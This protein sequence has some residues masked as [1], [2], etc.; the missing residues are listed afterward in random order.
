MASFGGVEFDT[1]KM[2]IRLLSKKL[3]KAK[4][5]VHE[6]QKAC[7]VSLVELQR[8][9]GFLNFASIVIPL[10]RTFLRRLYN[11]QLYF[12]QGK[13]QMRR[14]LSAEAQKDLVLWAKVL[15]LAPERSNQVQKWDI[16]SLWS[17]AAG[18]KELGA[19]YTRGT[20]QYSG[21]EPD[22]AFSISLPSY[23]ARAREHINTKEMR[24]VEQAL[25]YWSRRWK[26]LKV[27]IHVDNRAVAQGLENQTIRG[28]PMTILRRCL[29]LAAEHDLDLEARWIPTKENALADALSWF[30][31][32][33]IDNLAS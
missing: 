24:V 19:F 20:D 5:I 18:I 11:M 4:L 8:I 29:L 21:P 26:G 3:Q 17:D 6:A 16:V 13:R 14:R 30:D 7:S 10:G 27:I 32:D 23:I 33:R 2:I 25:L 15:L 22:S 31:Y 28:A 12:T 1:G 9:T